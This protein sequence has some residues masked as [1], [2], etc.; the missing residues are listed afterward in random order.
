MPVIEES[1]SLR[2]GRSPVDSDPPPTPARGGSAPVLVVVDDPAGSAVHA[3]P[4][5]VLR[6]F[7]LV[8]V[9]APRP[10][11]SLNPAVHWRAGVRRRSGRA[12]VTAAVHRALVGC[13][14]RYRVLDLPFR[15]AGSAGHRP[16]TMW[17]AARRLADR[18][19]A[20]LLADWPAAAADPGSRS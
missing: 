5:L 2:A 15:A 13:A 8:A 12:A 20:I 17:V 19:G 14:G 6:R 11:L 3:L 18:H 4:G 7:V 10:V 1:F 9:P 16:A